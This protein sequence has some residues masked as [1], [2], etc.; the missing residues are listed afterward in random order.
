MSAYSIFGAIFFFAAPANDELF[1]YICF[2][3]TIACMFFAAD[4]LIVLFRADKKLKYLKYGWI[5]ILSAIPGIFALRFARIFYMFR[6]IK[7]LRHFRSLERFSKFFANMGVKDAF[8][9][10]LCMLFISIAVSGAL[11]LHFEKDAPRAN[12]LN[13]GDALWW[14]VSTVST[15]GYG[16]T[17]PVT[18]G[19]R[20]V[21]MCLIFVG[22]GLFGT[23]SALTA[24]II[25]KGGSKAEELMSDSSSATQ[26]L[27]GEPTKINAPTKK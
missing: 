15:V 27:F 13:A 20:I 2:A 25:L 19:G 10:V 8:L 11:E 3:D 12:I 16:D 6:N 21:G 9:G 18:T 22:I 23:F 4:F 26:P 7:L 17:Y 24:S 14:A 1:K 5:D